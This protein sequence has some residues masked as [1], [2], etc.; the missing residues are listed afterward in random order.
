VVFSIF[1]AFLVIAYVVTRRQ[2]LEVA[3][4]RAGSYFMDLK[5][6]AIDKSI[7]LVDI[8]ESAAARYRGKVDSPRISGDDSAGF[9]P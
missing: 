9:M 8:V 4:T 3:S 2:V 1:A 7:E 6:S 5:V